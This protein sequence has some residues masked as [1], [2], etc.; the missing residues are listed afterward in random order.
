MEMK[1]NKFLKATINIRCPDVD[2]IFTFY[3]NLCHIA[4]SFNI[5]L[6]PLEV[7]TRETGTC[8]LTPHNCLGYINIKQSMAAALYLKLIGRTISKA[9][10]KP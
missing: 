10:L 3:I 5:L 1:S 8:K 4:A 2:T 9:S 7:I 6:L